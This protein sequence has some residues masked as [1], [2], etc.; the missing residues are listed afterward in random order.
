MPDLKRADC[1]HNP[2]ALEAEWWLPQSPQVRVR[3]TLSGRAASDL[4]LATEGNLGDDFHAGEADLIILGESRAGERYTLLQCFST[5]RAGSFDRSQ[6][7]ATYFAHWLLIGEHFEKYEDL[8][9]DR[10]YFGISNLEE[11]HNIESFD[12]GFKHKERTATVVY[13]N[14]D[15]VTLLETEEIT[16]TL[17]YSY[18]PSGSCVAQQSATIEHAAR[19]NLRSSFSL[20]LYSYADV[21]RATFF[22]YVQRIKSFI[23]FAIGARVFPYDIRAYSKKFPEPVDSKFLRPIQVFR[24]LN[25]TNSTEP[26]PFHKMLFTW[27]HMEGA[28]Q[29]HFQA[30]ES[31]IQ[32]IGMSAWLYLGSFREQ[33]FED[34]RFLELAQALEGYHRYRF[35]ESSEKNYEHTEKLKQILDAC[36]E[37]HR[38]WLDGKLA[39]SHEPSLRNRLKGLFTIHKGVISWLT[40][41]WKDATECICRIVD[42]RNELSHCLGDGSPSL[43]GLSRNRTIRVMQA[44]LALL[45][46]EDAE[47]SEAQ[48]ERIIK[49]N[50]GYSQLHKRLTETESSIQQK[51]DVP[52]SP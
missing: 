42:H 30:W 39:Y 1:V 4:L 17:E 50:W 19:I 40:G 48:I 46:L 34:Q 22:D 32:S 26:V 16:A 12:V 27:K 36:P 2:I 15:P 7:D 18:R 24:I 29:K 44:A 6:A 41:S 9:F 33:V 28:P 10:I 14:P 11:W 21:S 5:K 20:P 45:L 38:E 51:G 37:D 31:K 23:E 13:T 3:G 49:N 35:P 43:D 52:E 47:F 8:L 25:V